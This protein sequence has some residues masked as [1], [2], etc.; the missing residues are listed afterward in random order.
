M[1]MALQSMKECVKR[2]WN[3]LKTTFLNVKLQ[4]PLQISSSTV[5]NIIKRLWE[6]GE[7]SVRKGQG[8]R[9]LL[10]ARAFLALR[11]HCIT[12]QHDSVIEITKW[13]QEYFQ[14]PLSVNTI[15]RAICSPPDDVN[16]SRTMQNHIL[17]LLKQ[18]GFVV[19]N[20]NLF[21][22]WKPIAGKNGNNFQNLD[23]QTSSD[24]FEKKSRCYTMVDMP[25]PQLFWDLVAGIKFEM[26]SFCEYFFFKFLSLNIC[27]VIYVLLWI[28]YWLMWFEILL[29][30][31][32]FKFNK[33]PNISGIWV[34]SEANQLLCF[35]CAHT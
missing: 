35:V 5:H 16:F 32:L 28:K 26:S 18:Y 2:L 25:P 20:H 17:Q 4:K 12:H 1:G 3:T 27:Y 9:P 13:A 24:C 30:F 15:R 11:R 21:N 29:V 10:D 19:D 31:I 7:I 8:R 14:K 23:A 6:T 34:V 33:C 22:S